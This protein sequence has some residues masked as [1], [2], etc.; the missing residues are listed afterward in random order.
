MEGKVRR[1]IEGPFFDIPAASKALLEDDGFG[2]G[3]WF[4]RELGQELTPR[5]VSA[6]VMEIEEELLR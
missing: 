3:I 6:T 4:Q 5:P 1:G 2:L